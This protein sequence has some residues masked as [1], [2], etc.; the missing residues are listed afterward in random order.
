RRGAIAC[1][2]MPGSNRSVWLL[3]IT[4]VFKPC[5]FSRPVIR[6]LYTTQSQMR[7][8]LSTIWNRATK[9]RKPGVNPM[10]FAPFVYATADLLPH[11]AAF[12]PHALAREDLG[13]APP[14][15]VQQVEEEHR[16]QE[17]GP[18]P[19]PAVVQDDR[20]RE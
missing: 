16:V 5:R 6:I 11:R 15:H 3:T 20:P 17:R 14:R 19:Q 4:A 10:M 7:T 8:A 13:E 18:P 1:A 2:M 12:P 9:G